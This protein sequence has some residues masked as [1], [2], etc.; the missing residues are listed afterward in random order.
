[1]PCSKLAGAGTKELQ[2]P[3][4]M[5]TPR[6]ASST[7]IVTGAEVESLQACKPLAL[8]DVVNSRTC[9]SIV[10]SLALKNT[11]TLLTLWLFLLS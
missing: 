8:T 11:H 5:V 6:E 7:I 2:L 9:P 10:G 3:A 1:M 4:Q